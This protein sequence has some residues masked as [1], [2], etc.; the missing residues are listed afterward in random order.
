MYT[1][2]SAHSV[3]SSVR[4]APKL[5]A[6]LTKSSRDFFARSCFNLSSLICPSSLSKS[7]SPG[8]SINIGVFPGTGIIVS[9][10]GPGRESVI[11]LFVL[12]AYDFPIE[13]APIYSIEF[14]RDSLN[15]FFVVSSAEDVSGKSEWQD[16]TNSAMKHIMHIPRT[17]IAIFVVL[18]IFWFSDWVW[19]MK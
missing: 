5:S 7:K 9:L 11:I 4:C 1:H 6:A 17:I 3:S 16:S 12:L 8:N 18:F 10:I 15:S 14:L 19:L 2:P 13:Q